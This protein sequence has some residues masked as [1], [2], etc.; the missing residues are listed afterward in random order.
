MFSTFKDAIIDMQFNEKSNLL[1]MLLTLV[2]INFSSMGFKG[3][4]L[5]TSYMD[6][7]MSTV[8]ARVQEHH[9]TEINQKLFSEFKDLLLQNTIISKETSE[10]VK[11]NFEKILS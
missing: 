9:T 3:S 1:S 6:P 11:T 8:S 7:S 2:D 5:N 10:I 4:S